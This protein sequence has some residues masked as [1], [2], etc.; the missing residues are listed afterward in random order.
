MAPATPPSREAFPLFPLLFLAG[1]GLASPAPPRC[2][3]AFLNDDS[4]EEVYI[5]CPP[6][7]VISNTK[8]KVLCLR[9][10]LYSLRHSLEAWNA[11]LDSTLKRMGFQHCAYEAIV[12]WR[13][14]VYIDN[15]MINDTKEGEVEPFK[16]E[17]KV[18]L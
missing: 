9:K 4:K 15:F 16:A 1:L 14:K 13:G 10:A 18:T 17:M 5:C 2:S 6:R 8:S 3:S 7:F 12:H 11:K